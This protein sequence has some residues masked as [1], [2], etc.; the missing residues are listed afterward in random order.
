MSSIGNYDISRVLGKGTFG[1]TYLGYDKA[2]NRQ[3]AVKTIDINKSIQRGSNI[4]AIDDEIDSLRV[5]SENG[6]SAFISEYYDSFTAMYNGVNTKFVIS[7]FIDGSSL[8]D[9]IEKGDGK[10]DPGTLWPVM[11]QLIN[12]IKY[13]HNKGYAHRDIKPENV[14]IT[15][16]FR[17]KYIDF[18][19]ACTSACR[20][21]S[22][23][24]VCGKGK[25][26][27]GTF[28]YRPPENFNKT[29][30]EDLEMAK[31]H[32]MWSL[33]VMF[34]E[35]CDGLNMY[36]YKTTQGG[37]ELSDN[38]VIENMKQ[39]PTY[40][41]DY[42]FDKD[43]RTR[44]FTYY[45][46]SP[47]AQKRPTANQA[48]DAMIDHVLSIPWGT[49]NP[50]IVKQRIQNRTTA[51]TRPHSQVS[52]SS[53]IGS[54][55]L[56][57]DT[58][59]EEEPQN[60][61]MKQNQVVFSNRDSSSGYQPDT[62][63][64]PQTVFPT[65]D[66]SS[67]YQAFLNRVPG[68]LNNQQRQPTAINPSVQNRLPPP[69]V[70]NNIPPSEYLNNQQRQSTTINGNVQNTFSPPPIQQRRPTAINGNV[71]NTFSPSLPIQNNIPP[72]AFPR[73]QNGSSQRLLPIQEEIHTLDSLSGNDR[74]MENRRPSMKN[75][76]PQVDDSFNPQMNF[77][78][79]YYF[80]RQDNSRGSSML[81]PLPNLSNGNTRY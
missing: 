29:Y 21:A 23:T 48:F 9:F 3:V 71:Q 79:E 10:I 64:E 65:R 25:G 27:P 70:Q 47:D 16:D 58:D 59:T 60:G 22:C 19:F 49:A 7:E 54:S 75:I 73:S 8:L 40:L 81:P 77:D 56:N 62:K 44:Y 53:N 52:S 50:D 57:S 35:L 61:M 38:Q 30:V 6:G 78:N 68:Y 20:T 14:L 31:A 11:L 37:R 39:A 1:V 66:L 5:L 32:D 26:R 34:Y 43:G 55:A 33:S 28:N 41:V 12:G 63:D 15:K 24:N 69:P 76:S 2:N 4:G 18:G 13:I 42:N 46:L 80:D 17:V 36:P 67:G 45:L 74:L 72:P 51:P